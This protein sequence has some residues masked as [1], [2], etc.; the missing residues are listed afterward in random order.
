YYTNNRAANQSTMTAVS[1]VSSRGFVALPAFSGSSSRGVIVFAPDEC[2]EEAGRRADEL[3]GTLERNGVPV[4][5]SSSVNFNTQNSSPE[6]VQRLMN[7][8]NG[9][10]PIVVIRGKGKSNP[11]VAEVLAE[12]RGG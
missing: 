4:V 11:P 1:S 12:Y 9:E 3:V 7:V 6:E 2:P 5:R 8:M 10:L